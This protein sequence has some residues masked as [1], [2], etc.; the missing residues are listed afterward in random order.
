MSSTVCILFCFGNA[1]NDK[2]KADDL[3]NWKIGLVVA[4][5]VCL[6]IAA[7]VTMIA[8]REDIRALQCPENPFL[9]SHARMFFNDS[10]K[11]SK[12]DAVVVGGDL[13]LVSNFHGNTHASTIAHLKGR[14]KTIII[15]DGEPNDLSDA[16]NADLIV[17]TKLEPSLLPPKTAT[18]YLPCY[19]SFL[20]EINLQ[21]DALL[22][23][24]SPPGKREFAVFCYSNC[25][26]VFAGVRAR[27]VFYKLM[28]KMT[29]N[30][31][32]NLG[33]CFS[34]EPHA[35]SS[36]SGS[37]YSHFTNREM[38]TNFKFVIA[39]ENE[40]IRGYISEKLVNPLLAN[41]VPIYMGAPDVADHFNPKRIINVSS[42]PSFEACINEVLRLD[43][44]DEAYNAILREPC[45]V[46][47]ELNPD[48]FSLQLG[49]KFY[50]TLYKHVPKTVKVRPTMITRNTVHLLAV[51]EHAAHNA[52]TLN[53]FDSSSNC[54]Q[55]SLHEALQNS[56]AETKDDDLI[57][58][59][60]SCVTFEPNMEHEMVELYRSAIYCGD[61]DVVAFERNNGLAEQALVVR[62]TPS[63]VALIND[64]VQRGP[65]SLDAVAKNYPN[66]HVVTH[67][68]KTP[69]RNL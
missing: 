62:K 32:A 17:T 19:S 15:V 54:T 64:W 30:R 10:I 27:G 16:R 4:V 57:V 65:G 49:G 23:I 45:F 33:Q 46:N 22:S 39:F 35:R 18:L 56:L 29:G 53:Y 59:C 69:L 2:K 9:H 24:K 60:G 36:V 13:A 25:F 55:E 3:M 38:F 12:R 47:N 40:S 5:V 52:Q 48:H 11:Q 44:D 26:K 61:I 68:S 41:S 42:F 7:T 37:E 6:V 50:N 34:D 1:N 58:V 51:T 28:Q 14:G 63:S 20:N 67:G 43:A 21:P 31:V 8:K 66:L